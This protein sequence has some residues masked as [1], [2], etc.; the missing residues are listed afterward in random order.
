M[1]QFSNLTYAEAP[2]MIFEPVWQMSSSSLASHPWLAPS[3]LVISIELPGFG[4]SVS[5]LG[6]GLSLSNCLG[7]GIWFQGIWLSLSK[8]LGLRI[9]FQ[10]LG[11]SLSKCLGLGIWFQ[12]LGLS[13]SKCLGLRIWFQGFPRWQ[14][15]LC[16]ER[17]IQGFGFPLLWVLSCHRHWRRLS[18]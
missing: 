8:C 18:N 15:N 3:L 1:Y 5:G 12:G 10:G 9:W 6:L 2:S 13:L 14:P 11:L 4:D 7:L 16:I 17:P